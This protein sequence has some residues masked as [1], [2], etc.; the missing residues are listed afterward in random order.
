[1]PREKAKRDE[2]LQLIRGYNASLIFYEAPHRLS[3][4]LSSLCQNGLA[5]R[6]AILL[7]EL[8]KRYESWHLLRVEELLDLSLH[9]NLKGE[10]VLVIDAPC[11][12]ELDEALANR[13]LEQNID[14]EKIIKE[15]LASNQALKTICSEIAEEYKLRKNDVYKLALELKNN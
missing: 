2:I 7:R 14:L 15:R 12:S 4:M 9:E 3:Q 11:A 6:K 1:M 10:M 5:K 13:K 8:S